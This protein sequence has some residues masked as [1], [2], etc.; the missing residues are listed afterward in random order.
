MGRQNLEKLIAEVSS[1]FINIENDEIDNSI[2]ESL[3]LI[4]N[5]FRVDRSYVFLYDPYKKNF[6][7]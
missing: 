2:N 3:R 1:R 6:R 4:G 5:Y 7:A